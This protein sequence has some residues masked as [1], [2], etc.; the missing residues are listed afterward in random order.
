[1][2]GTSNKDTFWFDLLLKV[3]EVKV[4]N[5]ISAWSN[6]K[7]GR[8]AAIL[9]NQQSYWPET[10]YILFYP[11]IIPQWASLAFTAGCFDML[12]PPREPLK[13]ACLFET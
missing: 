4:Q 10:L 8:Q 9:E 3:T 5:Q 2:M 11:P 12:S 13:A 7:Y 1:M 6:F